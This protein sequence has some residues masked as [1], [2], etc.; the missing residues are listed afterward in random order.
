MK[1]LSKILI[2]FGAV[3]IVFGFSLIYQ[4]YNPNRLEFH[5]LSEKE[6]SVSDVKPIEIS[7]PAL[8]RRLGVFSANNSNNNWDT[9]DKGISHLSSSPVPGESGNSILY[10]HNYSNLLG[11]LDKVKPGDE[12]NIT[13][14]NGEV[15]NFSIRY[16]TEVTPNQT[17][18]LESSDDSRITLYTCSGFLDSKRFVVTAVLNEE[19]VASGI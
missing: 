2:V 9:T 7:I 15:R 10:G 1:Y 5:N 17:E 8:D 3:T 19:L 18:I 13:M 16:T 11:N 14:S 12:I 4:R 6:V